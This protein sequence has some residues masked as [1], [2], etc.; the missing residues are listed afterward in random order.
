MSGDQVTRSGDRIEILGELRGEVMVYE[1]M[2][3]TEISHTGAQVETAFPLQIDSLH[4]FRL[5]LGGSSI[6]V[7]G[8][9]VHSHVCDVEEGKTIYRAG[10]EFVQPSDRA[11]EAIAEFMSAVAAGRAAGS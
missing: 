9:I 5:Q 1:P 8:R 10:V 6:V 7:K 4:D 3:I 2:A 11:L